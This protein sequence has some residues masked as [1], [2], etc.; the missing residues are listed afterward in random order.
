MSLVVSSTTSDESTPSSSSR[1]SGTS[2]ETPFGREIVALSEK[3]LKQ[4]AM[5]S[6]K[7]KQDA[8]KQAE[9]T[10]SDLESVKGRSEDEETRLRDAKR[11]LLLNEKPQFAGR[12]TRRGKRKA[13]KKSRKT[14]GRRA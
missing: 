2:A 6:L 10:V 13:S 14:K 4:S 11:Y 3:K 7:A 8:W 1:I 5:S 9:K 12:K